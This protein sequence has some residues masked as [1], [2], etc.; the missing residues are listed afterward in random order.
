M[1]LQKHSVEKK[2]QD[3]MVASIIGKLKEENLVNDKEFAKFWIESRLRGKPKG[4]II[5]RSEL[6]QKGVDK[7]VIDSEYKRAL[8][9]YP[10]DDA[11]ERL[12]Q[13]ASQK[14]KNIAGM[15]KRQKITRFIVSRG[16]T[17]EKVRRAIDEKL[18]KK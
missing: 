16:F 18:K 4:E 2:F 8:M 3:E 1:F 12:Y 5:I 7:E 13:K 6:L 17:Y 10:V 14:Y 11:I 9:E 15:E